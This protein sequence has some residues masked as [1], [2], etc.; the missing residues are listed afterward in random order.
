[1]QSFLCYADTR[2]I[3]PSHLLH[4]VEVNPVSI[5]LDLPHLF[6]LDNLVLNFKV[7]RLDV[8]VIL[9]DSRFK[10]FNCHIHIQ[11]MQ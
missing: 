7:G 3:V 1:M 11:D 2:D 6:Q 5:Q 8:D 9:Q 10:M 4:L